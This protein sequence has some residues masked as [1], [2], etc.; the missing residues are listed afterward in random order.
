MYDGA[1]E[2]RHEWGSNSLELRLRLLEQIEQQA[3]Q[4]SSLAS[5]GRFDR[6]EIYTP[7]GRIL[8]QVRPDRR[9]FVRSAGTPTGT[10]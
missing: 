9:L 10:A 1:G 2:V 7:E 4:V 5:V 3:A 8:C 6:L